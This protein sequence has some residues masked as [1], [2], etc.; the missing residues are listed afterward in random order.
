MS[1]ASNCP[2][3]AKGDRFVHSITKHC[4]EL[5]LEEKGGGVLA[6][7]MGMG[8]TLSILAL[9]I[10]TL[11]KARDWALSQAQSDTSVVKANRYSRATLI[12]VS[13]A[14]LIN[15]WFAE[16]ERH[17]DAETFATLKTVRWHG[18]NRIAFQE[19]LLDADIVITTYNTLSIEYKSKPSILH[20]TEWFRVVLDEAHIIRRQATIFY[21]AC[22]D[23]TALTRWCLTGTPI[24]NRVEDIGTLFAFIRAR[25]FHS[26]AT[27]RQFMV[28]PYDEGGERR[29]I[30]C[31]R[32]VLVL[33]SLCLRRTKE[34]LHLPGRKDKVVPVILKGKERDQYKSTK[35]IMDRILRQSSG[36]YDHINRFG[37][38]QAMLQLR[39]FC[40]HGTFQRPF[41]WNTISQR[42]MRE[43]AISALGQNGETHCSGCKLPM[44]VLGSNRIY[45]VFV[46]DC[47]HVLC[48]ECL[49][50]SSGEADETVLVMTTGTG[51]FGLNLTAA[52]H[53]FLVE[54]QWNPSVEDQAIART[55]RLGQNAQVIV[56]RYVVQNSIEKDMLSQQNRKRQI[57]SIRH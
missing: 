38:F 49:E 43:A 26:L 33:D 46:E 23:L 14:L 50:D 4:S 16:I 51:A 18:S 40:N 9:V 39:I 41:S 54:P 25:P 19:A 11:E 12:I 24:Q 20:D 5:D 13:S 15:G 42:D 2:Y 34:L 31:E 6:D 32:L 29:R 30:A 56:T 44:P 45:R 48:S 21:K 1:R 35:R 10:G 3:D 57:A 53:V 7:E 8:K 28:I 52:N 37:M 17:L 22:Y 55:I 47:A 36:L 27:F